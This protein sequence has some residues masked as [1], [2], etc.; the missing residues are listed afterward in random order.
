VPLVGLD[1]DELFTE[2]AGRDERRGT[3]LLQVIAPV[4]R[5]GTKFL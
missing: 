4:S 1:S 2:S 5:R 3:E